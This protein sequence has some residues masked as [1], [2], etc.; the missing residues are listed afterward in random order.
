MR[1]IQQR[2]V[3]DV[4]MARHPADVGG[5]KVQVRLYLSCNIV[6]LSYSYI[7]Y[8]SIQAEDAYSLTDAVWTCRVWLGGVSGGAA[9]GSNCACAAACR[10]RTAVRCAAGCLVRSGL[11]TACSHVDYQR[12]VSQESHNAAPGI[13]DVFEGG[14]SPH[15]VTACCVQHTLWSA[16]RAALELSKIDNG[17]NRRRTRWCR[18]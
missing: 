15:H 1:A 17:G 18:E 5:A 12:N 6:R 16:R 9:C 4:G 13:E 7:A 11:P 3:H 14:G 10:A 8:I 2:A